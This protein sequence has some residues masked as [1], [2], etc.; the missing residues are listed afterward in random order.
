MDVAATAT[1]FAGDGAW[2]VQQIRRSVCAST[3]MNSSRQGKFANRTVS[4]SM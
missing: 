4:E 2:E 1:A 3:R